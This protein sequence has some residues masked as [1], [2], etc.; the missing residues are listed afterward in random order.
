[1][2]VRIPPAATIKIHQTMD[3]VAAVGG[4]LSSRYIGTEPVTGSGISEVAGSVLT[5]YR[6]EGREPCVIAAG[7][8][9]A[10]V[11]LPTL[12]VPHS[13]SAP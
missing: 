8:L 12:Q 1:M 10:G 7:C 3:G 2:A 6:R 9:P 5:D 4:G 11:P 13:P